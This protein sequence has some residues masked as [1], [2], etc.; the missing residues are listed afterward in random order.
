MRKLLL[1]I[2]S[3]LVIGCSYQYE[4]RQYTK[5]DFICL[6]YVTWGINVD[7]NTDVLYWY[8]GGGKLPCPIFKPD[9]TCLTLTE[10]QEQNSRMKN[11]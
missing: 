4:G 9:G 5:D 2:C 11:D 8:G 3:L 10:W 6:Q 7:V 1:I